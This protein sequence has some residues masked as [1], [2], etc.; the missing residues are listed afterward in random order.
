MDRGLC[1]ADAKV[2][3]VYT[4]YSVSVFGNLVSMFIVTLGLSHQ[5]NKYQDIVAVAHN[6]DLLPYYRIVL[7]PMSHMISRNEW[8]PLATLF[9]AS[10]R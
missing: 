9:F 5:S 2:A 8:D 6:I 4:R 3:F 10:N 1:R 7:V